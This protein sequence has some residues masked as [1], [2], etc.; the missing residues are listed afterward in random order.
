MA[1]FKVYYGHGFFYCFH[2]MSFFKDM[3]RE[4]GFDFC[5]SVIFPMFFKSCVEVPDGSSYIK[6]VAVGA[7]HIINPLLVIFVI[8]FYFI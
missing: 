3:F 2:S 5:V 6:F 4:F 1:I 7:C 8:L